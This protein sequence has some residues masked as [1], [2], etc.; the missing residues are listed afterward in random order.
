M[1]YTVNLD[2]NNYILSVAHTDNDNVELNLD[3]MEY[4]YL[5]AY[6]LM[7]GSAVLDLVK[8][9]EL[10][11][12]DAAREKQEQIEV[13]IHQLESTNDDMLGFLEDLFTLKNPLTFISDMFAL[14]KNYTS[15][16]AARQEI[17]EQIKELRK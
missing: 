13:L 11:A 7:D 8:K 16:V 5:S 6:K 17:R 12:E 14:M 15:L 4:Q 3:D 10:I 2:D 9:A 1:L